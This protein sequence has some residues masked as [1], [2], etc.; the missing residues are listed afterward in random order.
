MRIIVCVFFVS[1]RP[2]YLNLRTFCIV[3]GLDAFCSPIGLSVYNLP[4]I[5][6][7]SARL[8]VDRAPFQDGRTDGRV[9]LQCWHRSN[10]APARRRLRVG[11]A[12]RR[13]RFGPDLPIRQNTGRPQIPVMPSPCCTLAKKARFWLVPFKPVRF[14]YCGRSDVDYTHRKPNVCNC[15]DDV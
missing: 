14:S 10:A 4:K 1:C 3:Y 15:G 11:G 13:T 6:V 12:V 8:S 9:C 5:S 2:V 7:D